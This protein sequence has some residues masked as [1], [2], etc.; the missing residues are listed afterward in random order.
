MTRHK[1]IFTALPNKRGLTN[2]FDYLRKT[3]T[4]KYLKFFPAFLFLCVF[5]FASLSIADDESKDI[6]EKDIDAIGLITDHSG[7]VASGFFVNGNTFVTNF[8]VSSELDIKSGKIQMKDDREFK[9]KKI[10]KEYGKQDLAIIETEETSDM[11]LEL[12]SDRTIREDDIVYSVGNPTDEWNDV[13][14]FK[15]TKGAIKRIDTD[16][17]YYDK[18]QKET[19]R[20]SALVIQHTAIIHP[21][22][23]GGPLL[24]NKGQVIG[25][26]TFFYDDSL[27]YAVHVDELIKVLKKNDIAFNKKVEKK[28]L[29][30]TDKKQKK[31]KS[32]NEKIDKFFQNTNNV[33]LVFVILCFSYGFFIIFLIS[34]ISFIVILNN[35]KRRYRH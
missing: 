5:F 15:M 11:F 34:T 9:I 12:N 25:V 20:H 27:N 13:N 6:Y 7:F 29:E 35:K 31:E 22:N 16:D 33:I 2:F 32:L 24:N 19:D 8:H 23:S 4:S 3:K 18:N 30:I 1:S 17:W 10:I 28:N 14:Y 21:G 26:N